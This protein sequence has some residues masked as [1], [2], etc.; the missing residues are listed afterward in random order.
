MKRVAL[1]ETD[2][3]VA[4]LAQR[5]HPQSPTCNKEEEG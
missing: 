2:L 4:E 5:N 3:S 1:E